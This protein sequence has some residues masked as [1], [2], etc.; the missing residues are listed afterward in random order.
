MK[1]RIMCAVIAVSLFNLL[2][3]TAM[4]STPSDVRRIG[5]VEVIDE[6]S[7]LRDG[8]YENGE[9]VNGSICY[10]EAEAQAEIEA[11]KAYADYLFNNGPAPREG[12]YPPAGTIEGPDSNGNFNYTI[13]SSGRTGS[14]QTTS[15]TLTVLTQSQIYRDLSGGSYIQTKDYNYTVSLMDSS[16]TSKGTFIAYPD[17]IKGG[18]VFDVTS[19]NNYYLKITANKFPLNWYLNGSGSLDKILK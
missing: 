11:D 5:D 15:N 19:W 3:T 14:F 13:A 9:L 10:S 17:N 6:D 1:K 16:G 2:T 7:Y 18:L 12:V 4:A 8:D